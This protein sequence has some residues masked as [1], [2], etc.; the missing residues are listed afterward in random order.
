MLTKNKKQKI[1]GETGL[2]KEDSGSADVQIALITKRIEELA[3]HLKTHTKDK[4]SRKGLLQLVADRQSH[5]NYLQKKDPKR[6]NSL[7]KKLKIKKR[8]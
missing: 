2:H 1:M 5:M 6:F 8:A 7:M 4:H 3:D